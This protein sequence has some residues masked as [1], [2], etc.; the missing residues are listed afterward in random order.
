MAPKRANSEDPK[1]GEE[2]TRQRFRRRRVRYKQRFSPAALS[3]FP[4]ARPQHLTQD[5]ALLS[6]PVPAPHVPPL[7][8]AAEEVIATMVNAGASNVA[9]AR[10]RGTNAKTVGNQF[11]SS[12]ASL[13]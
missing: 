13:A 1:V 8:S 7:L 6:I 5:L 3:I 9:I 12:T 4:K 2:A 11:G 10:A